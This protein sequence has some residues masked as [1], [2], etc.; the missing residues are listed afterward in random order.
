MKR[1]IRMVRQGKVTSVDGTE[2]AMRVDT[3]CI[4]GDGPHADLLPLLDTLL[5]LDP[6]QRRAGATM[7][8]SIGELLRVG[9]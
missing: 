6:E 4:H 8:G 3:I 1:A 5:R 9:G 7:L 2:L